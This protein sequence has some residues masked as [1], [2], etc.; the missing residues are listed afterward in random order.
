MLL[1]WSECHSVLHGWH[2][3]L[4]ASPTYSGSRGTVPDSAVCRRRAQPT[5]LIPAHCHLQRASRKN[6]DLS[7]REV[8]R[9]IVLDHK[10]AGKSSK[11]R[12][13]IIYKLTS[14]PAIQWKLSR[15]APD[16]IF[17]EFSASYT[18]QIHFETSLRVRT[19]VS[20]K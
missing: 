9:W 1:S 6:G 12:V 20:S 13:T 18:R 4:T 2:W 16:S 17:I 7:M 8:W 15:A 14:R 11:L 19:P 5:F 3:L 10:P